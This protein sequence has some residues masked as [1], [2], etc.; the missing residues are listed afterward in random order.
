MS[1]PLPFNDSHIYQRIFQLDDFKIGGRLEFHA[2]GN[3][4]VMAFPHCGGPETIQLSRPPVKP[5]D[6]EERGKEKPATSSSLP[7]VHFFAGQNIGVLPPGAQR[8]AHP[9]SPPGTFSGSTV[10]HYHPQLPNHMPASLQPVRRE[11]EQVRSP[12]PVQKTRARVDLG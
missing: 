11:R 6:K 12:T 1:Q 3:K 7:G 10:S 5:Q 9:T 4:L 8:P 2:L